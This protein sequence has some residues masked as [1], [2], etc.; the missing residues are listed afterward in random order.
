MK[1]IAVRLWFLI[2]SLAS[3][4]LFASRASADKFWLTPTN[5]LWQ[6]ATNWSGGAAPAGGTNA[7]T[8]W[9]TNANSK[10]VTIDA[11]TPSTNLAAIKLNLWA[12]SNTATSNAFEVND[13]HAGNP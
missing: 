4:I 7:T 6:V 10:V 11:T 5:G 1:R 12:W 9:I 13:V 3:F 2:A 8:V